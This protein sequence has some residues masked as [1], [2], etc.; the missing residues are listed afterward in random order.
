MI[1]KLPIKF[2]EELFKSKLL[3]VAV[4]HSC[5]RRLSKNHDEESLCKVF[6]IIAKALEV[7]TAKQAMDLYSDSMD[8]TRKGSHHPGVL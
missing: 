8:G 5:V 4:M 6:R 7:V 1:T 2:S 3:S